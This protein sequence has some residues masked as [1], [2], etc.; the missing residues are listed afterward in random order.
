[1]SN[2]SKMLRK[3]LI[4]LAGFVLFTRD[5]RSQDVLITNIRLADGTGAPLRA[6]DVRL[7]DD[8]IVAVGKLSPAAGDRIIDGR[9]QVLAPG[10]I[11]SHSHHLG[12]LKRQPDA[13]ATA[14][15]G[16]TTIVIGQDGN[17]L[18]MDSL[19]SL[20]S[21]PSFA[22]NIATYTGQTMLREQAMGAGNLMRP[23]TE[24]EIS[25]MKKGLVREMKAGSL[26]LSTGLEYE[27]AFY[28]IPGEVIDLAKTAASFGG[29]YISH[30]RSEDLR[31][32][33]AVEEIINI[34][35]VTGMPVKL[36]HIKIASRDDWGRASEV[37]NRLERARSEGI[38]ITA[39]AY[40][41]TFW[42]ST[43]KVLFPD[44]RYTDTASARLAVEKLC[45]PDSSM[46]V[47]FLPEPA[48]EGRMLG[49]IARQ[50]GESP[51]LTLIH[52]IAMA[53]EYERKH[54]DAEGVEAIA[55]KSMTV[56]DVSAFLAW[57]HTNIC[58][59]GNA[60][61]HPRGF[62]AFTRVLGRHVRES[63]LMPLETAVHKMTGL[64]AAH[65]GL[66]DRGLIRPG[67]LADLVLLDPD[68]VIDHATLEDSHALSEGISRV[69]VNGKEV[70]QDGRSTGVRSGKL[71]TRP[72]KISDDQQTSKH[73][74]TIY[75]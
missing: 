45:D 14:S 25:A 71:V 13:L 58:S 4:L 22:V 38:D 18:P 72:Q 63:R 19:R 55:G 6:A 50:R 28:S 1:M 17:G 53:E 2:I 20:F 64:T 73:P 21:R 44:R 37:L 23:A 32:T 46:L 62:G 33:E 8:R 52:L 3:T 70:Y 5:I 30:I 74:K 29:R 27:G 75:P 51:A 35:K 47:R 24:A 40:P 69:W 31:M 66:R 54:P 48:Y 56:S 60:G 12:Y 11:D 42:N 67:Y 68:R 61:R 43:L 57:P 41:Y 7:R 16:I 26:G 34:G 49:D 10:F 39:D 59:D 15:Q 9:G 36:S 65:L